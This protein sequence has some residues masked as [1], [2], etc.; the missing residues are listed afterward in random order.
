MYS[1]EIQNKLQ[2]KNY[3][4]TGEEYIDICKNSSQI[5][6]VKYSGFDDTYEI[7]T[8]DNYYWKFRLTTKG[9]NL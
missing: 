1:W 3:I 6:H 9:E 4:L 7:W 2:K 5:S 8:T